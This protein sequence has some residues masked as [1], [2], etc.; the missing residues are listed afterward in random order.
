MALGMAM[1]RLNQ[2]DLKKH[3]ARAGRSFDRSRHKEDRG[4]QRPFTAEDFDRFL[5]DAFD[6]MPPEKRALAFGA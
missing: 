1:A 2:T 5:G 4:D 6:Q 3:E